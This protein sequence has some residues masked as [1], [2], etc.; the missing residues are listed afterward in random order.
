MFSSMYSGPS[1]PGGIHD[2]LSAR[3]FAAEA[4]VFSVQNL[5]LTIAFSPGR[6]L[7]AAT[8]ACRAKAA[9]RAGVGL[10]DEPA[11]RPE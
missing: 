10:A 5:D 7:D 3:L 1:L 4:P 2:A 6:T 8:H 9:S 11:T